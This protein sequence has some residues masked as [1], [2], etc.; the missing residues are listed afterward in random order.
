M[1]ILKYIIIVILSVIILNCN[2]N[3]KNLNVMTFN[4]KF[5]NLNGKNKELVHTFEN[6]KY[7]IKKTL[8]KYN[9]DVVGSQELQQWQLDELMKIL[10]KQWSYFGVPRDG[11]SGETN[12]IIYN[13]K[14]LKFIEGTTIWLSEKPNVV[15]SKSFNSN[16]PR[17]VTYAKFQH[18][19]TKKYFYIFNT[20]LDHKS[21]LAREKGIEIILNTMDKFKEYPIILTGDFN[22]YIDSPEL[23]NIVLNKTF[24][25][26]FSPFIEEFKINGKTTHGFNGGTV[27]KPIDFIFFK[28]D[29]FKIIETKIIRDMYKNK[30]FLSDHYPVYSKFDF[31]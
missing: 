9:I 18:L 21:S 16:K 29:K 17:I 13:N 6:R 24:I 31:I 14:K 23:N 5:E 8:S 30:Y 22:T 25:D 20:H 28:K 10:G 11:K 2:Y 1:R 15:G 7:G 12:A 27:G 4:M 3:D 26:S 19:S